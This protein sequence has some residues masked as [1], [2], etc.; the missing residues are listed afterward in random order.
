M[1]EGIRSLRNHIRT[2]AV[3]HASI[4]V[5]T[6]AANNHLRTEADNQRNPTACFETKQ[7]VLASDRMCCGMISAHG[8]SM[9][10]MRL[11]QKLCDFCP[12]P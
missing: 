6:C 3:L 7:I 8:A 5:R 9:Q 2:G 10:C 11:L 1:I 4:G 12:E